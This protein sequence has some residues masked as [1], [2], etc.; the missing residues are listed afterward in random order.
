MKLMKIR[1]FLLLA[2]VSLLCGC[3]VPQDEGT[4]AIGRPE[5]VSGV[6][7]SATTLHKKDGKRV[8]V[9]SASPRKGGN[10]DILADAFLRGAQEVGG[11]VEKIF[12]ADSTLEFLS[13]EGA[14]QPQSVTRNTPMGRIVE[15]F[16]AADV[17]VLA[18]PVYFM[19]VSDRM[20][21]F[22]DATYLGV[23]DPRMGNKE[24]YYLTAFSEQDTNTA[25]WIYNAFR[26]FVMWLPNSVERGHVGAAGMG[27]AGAVRGTDYENQ[28]YQLG[29]TINL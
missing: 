4:S 5:N 14:N 3:G 21:T 1:P 7:Q 24:Y 2:T 12:L 25:E 10:T 20:K 11:K 28:A 6:K 17:V 16:L 29:K 22:I 19:N 15:K 8:L 23:G 13:E 18:S 26:G 27:R 9:I